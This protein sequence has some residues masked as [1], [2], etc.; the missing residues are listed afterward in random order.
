MDSEKGVFEMKRVVV[1]R[2]FRL[3][4]SLKTAWDNVKDYTHFLYLHRK[5]FKDFDI[6]YDDGTIQ[7][8]HYRSKVLQWLPFVKQYLAVRIVDHDHH[9]YKQVYRE[10]GRKGLIF[11]KI[12]V[13]QEEGYSYIH[14]KFVFNVDGLFRLFPALCAWLLN[15]RLHGMAMED[16]AMVEEREKIGVFDNPYC[17]PNFKSVYASFLDNFDEAIEIEPEFYFED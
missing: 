5:F 9:S 10:V 12:W 17:S 16:R 8:F 13:T 3:N 6:V 14:N 1:E 7:I 4:G 2:K 15:R 11:S